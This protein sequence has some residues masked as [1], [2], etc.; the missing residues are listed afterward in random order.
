MEIRTHH[1]KKSDND[2]DPSLC[3]KLVFSRNDIK[4]TVDATDDDG[5]VDEGFI[6]ELREVVRELEEQNKKMIGQ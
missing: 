6:Y 5:W 4:L 3:I 2:N 1:Y